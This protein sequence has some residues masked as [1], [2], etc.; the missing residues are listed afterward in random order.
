MRRSQLFV[1]TRR[2]APADE[3]ARNAQLLIR[4]GFIHK[5]M[6]GVYSYLPLGMRVIENIKQIV[7]DE[8]DAVGGEEMLLSTLQHPHI[9]KS[10]DRWEDDKVDVWFK[11]ALGEDSEVGFGWSHEEPMARLMAQFINS[12]KD[13]PIYAYQFQNK[14]RR[15]PRA[16]SGLLRGREFIMKDLYSFSR[17]REQHEKFYELISQAY[18]KVYNRLGIGDITYKTFASGGPFS[19]F[20]HEFQTISDIG[21]DTVFLHEGQKTAINKEVLTD[22]VLADLKLSRNE[23]VEKKAVEVGNIFTFGSRY[24]EPLGLFF[25]DEKGIQQPV[26]MGSYGIGISRLMGL[27]AEHSADEKGLVWPAQVAPYK[28]YLARLGTAQAVTEAADAAYRQL[29][30]TGVGVIYDDRDA[31]AGEMF[32]DADLM[33]IPVRVVISDKTVADASAEIKN[34]SSKEAQIV[35][36]SA[37]VDSVEKNL[38]S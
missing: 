26:F 33:G 7:R 21:E 10:T 23:L 29:T 6:A 27:L 14:L 18:M 15:E 13:L 38:Q 4:A 12:Y 19:R 31:S 35:P 11:A 17:G 30:T 16:K 5:E 37:L 20:S 2:E 32:A 25:T 9:W 8:M 24:S 3:E 1:K 22:E 36:T 28:V 34:R